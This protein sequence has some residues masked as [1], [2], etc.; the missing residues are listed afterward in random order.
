MRL[1]IS[2]ALGTWT[3]LSEYLLTGCM[4]EWIDKQRFELWVRTSDLGQPLL[5]FGGG[6]QGLERAGLPRGH[7]QRAVERLKGCEDVDIEDFT[8]GWETRLGPC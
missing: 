5:Y 6:Y 2:A 7:T 4:S 8:P 1:Y 3:A